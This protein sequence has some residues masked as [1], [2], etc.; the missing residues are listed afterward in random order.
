MSHFDTFGLQ[1]V[2][3]SPPGQASDESMWLADHADATKMAQEAL[4]K[5]SLSRYRQLPCRTF[6]SVGTCPYHERCVYLHDPRIICHEAKTKTRR[7]NREDNE[8]D[9]LYWPHMPLSMMQPLSARQ[10]YVNQQYNVP[11]PDARRLPP[12]FLR[13]DLAVFS[14]WQHFVDYCASLLEPLPPESTNQD[15]APCFHP[16]DIPFNIYTSAMRL[17][18]FR[19]LAA[20]QSPSA[21]VAAIVTSRRGS[22]LSSRSSFVSIEG[23]VDLSEL[24]SRSASPALKA[25]CGS[26]DCVASVWTNPTTFC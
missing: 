9:S 14:L 26:P 7:K 16:V 13:H 10:P 19:I 23:S 5:Q 11:M 21:D 24:S 12:H 4:M 22:G 20:G 15:D 1:H 3:E 17:P 25:C 8:L 6:I 2:I 18:I